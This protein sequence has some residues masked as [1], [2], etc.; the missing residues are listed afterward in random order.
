[1]ICVNNA[2]VNIVQGTIYITVIFVISGIP[3]TGNL[4]VNANRLCV[5]S[6]ITQKHL[7]REKIIE[8]EIVI[9]VPKYFY[10]VVKSKNVIIVIFISVNIALTHNIMYN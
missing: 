7:T 4:Y 8:Q 6:V 2:T 1:M 9:Y 10:L 3:K 5:L